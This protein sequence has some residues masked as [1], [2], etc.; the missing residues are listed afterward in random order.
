VEPSPPDKR[1]KGKA[2]KRPQYT[3]S[4]EAFW[5]AYPQKRGKADAAKA[6]ANLTEEEREA[7]KSAIPAYIADCKEN[8]R[9]YRYGSTY[10]NQRTWDDYGEND[11]PEPSVDE[12]KLVQLVV[13]YGK[14]QSTWGP[15]LQE[16]LGP[17]PGQKGCTIPEW[18]VAKARQILKSERQSVNG[19][20]AAA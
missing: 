17:P 16:K 4:F 13:N 8:R 11:E 7:A 12:E 20:F 2:A 18:I 3:Q 14:D 9:P 10:L 1:K 15:R 19:A 6:W 5:K